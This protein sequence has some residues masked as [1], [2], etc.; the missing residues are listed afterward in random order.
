ML[1]A[2]ACA[3]PTAGTAVGYTADWA[4]ERAWAVPVGDAQALAEGILALMRDNLRRARMGQ[5]AREW[6]CAHDADWTAAQFLA[7]YARLVPAAGSVQI[8]PNDVC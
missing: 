1:E 7:L 3:L 2:A 4:P 6:A 8:D 5:A